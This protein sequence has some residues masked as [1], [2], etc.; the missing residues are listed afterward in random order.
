[1]KISPRMIAPLAATG[2]LATGLGGASA[3]NSASATAPVHTWKFV[4]IQTGSHSLGKFTFAGTDKD[5]TKG[6]V[7]G[8]DTIT[9]RFHVRT[10]TVDIDFALARKGGLMFG[11]VVGTEAGEFTGTV[12]G[13]TGRYKGAT[14]TVTGHNAPQNDKKTFLTVR[15]TK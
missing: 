9:G 14:G 6:K 15:W 3:L 4:A 2:L 12:R 8:F 13:G 11:H 7:V 1:M 10:R 5:R